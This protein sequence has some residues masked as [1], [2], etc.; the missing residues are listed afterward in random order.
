MMGYAFCSSCLAAVSV[1]V[2]TTAPLRSLGGSVTV[3]EVL[4]N[5]DLYRGKVIAVRAILRGGRHGEFLQDADGDEPCEGI[6]KRGRTWP[7]AVAITQYTRGSDIED[8]PATFESETE[9]IRT[10]L[11][12]AR[13]QVGRNSSLAILATFTGELRARK[14]IQIVRD[15]EGWYYG[16]GYGESGQY[17]AL[18]ILKTVR[19]VSVVKKGRRR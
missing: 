15:P 4:T 10:A 7:P 5:L 14:D 2:T 18:L 17:P 11:A 8:G 6:S 16:T 19:D 13:N 1:V 9:E 3:C 12:E